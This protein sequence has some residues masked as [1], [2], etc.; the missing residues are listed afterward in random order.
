MVNGDGGFNCEMTLTP[1]KKK[2]CTR[3]P[4]R[5]IEYNEGEIV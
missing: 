2:I 4:W 1:P 5:K 3:G